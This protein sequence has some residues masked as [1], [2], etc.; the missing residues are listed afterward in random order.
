MTNP[1]WG[2]NFFSFF[3]TL[4]SRLFDGRICAPVSDELQIGVLSAIAISC[5]LLGPFLILKKMTMFAN[6]LSHT[7]LIGIAASI[8]V[9]GSEAIFDLSHLAFGALIAAFATAFLTEGLIKLFGLQEDASI[10]LVFS[11]LFALGILFV[12]LFTRDLHIGIEAVMGN[13]DALMPSDFRI[14]GILALIN[15]SVIFLFFRHFQL[16]S[17][18]RNLSRSL[19][20]VSSSIFHFL[21]LFLVAATSIASFR[22]VGV[23]LVLAFLVGPYLVARLFCHRLKL[24][25][26]WSCAIGIAACV[27]GVAAARHALSVW[28][29]P[30][31][32]GGL[33]VC[34]IGAFY[35]LA[36]GI[37]SILSQ[38]SAR[39]APKFLPKN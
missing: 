9:L 33:V 37:H 5:G 31:S 30:L 2:T 19:G 3:T 27:V 38:I 15:G 10:G 34:V 25:L 36:V 6:S 23:L 29:L 22:A 7:I 13:V 35:V 18:D 12:T 39:K 16:A 32:T 26:I 4:I 28:D 21:L 11:F 17:F 8:L 14:I 24:L 1:Y 20:S